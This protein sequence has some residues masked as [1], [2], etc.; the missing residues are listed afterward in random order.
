MKYGDITSPDSK[1]AHLLFGRF[2][3]LGI[4]E[5][6]ADQP[7]SSVKELGMIPVEQFV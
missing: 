7:V 5:I 4:L 6:L 1:A 3:E 2:V